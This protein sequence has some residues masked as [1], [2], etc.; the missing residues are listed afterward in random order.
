M[1]T[2]S[3]NGLCALLCVRSVFLRILN[4][5]IKTKCAK[6]AVQMT[7]EMRIR[8]LPAESSEYNNLFNLLTHQKLFDLAWVLLQDVTKLTEI[9]LYEK[10]C[11]RLTAASA[12]CLSTE[13]TDLF[14]EKLETLGFKCTRVS[15]HRF[16]L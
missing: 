11:S 2:I 9:Q 10:T 3:P 5:C 12:K 7:M 6:M 14:K 4:H 8:G 1:R 13:K 15:D 16:R